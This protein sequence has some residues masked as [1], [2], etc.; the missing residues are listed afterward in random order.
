MDASKKLT[1]D[2]RQLSVIWLQIIAALFACCLLAQYT[3]LYMQCRPDQPKM[4][5]II[6][7]DS[8]DSVQEYHSFVTPMPPLCE[9]EL[10]HSLKAIRACDNLKD[11]Q[12]QEAWDIIAKR[13]RAEAAVLECLSAKVHRLT[14]IKRYQ[15]TASDSD[16]QRPTEPVDKEL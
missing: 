13:L 9:D 15:E 8:E 14:H 7:V 5:L 11:R 16:D 2:Q 12:T 10:K 1:D 4:L 6:R 3:I